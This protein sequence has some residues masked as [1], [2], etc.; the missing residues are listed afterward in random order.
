MRVLAVR[1]GIEVGTAGE[2]DS[3]EDVERLGDAVVRGG[4][5]SG[6]PPARSTARTYAS[7][8]RA[9]GSVQWP[10][11]ASGSAYVVIPIRGRSMT[12]S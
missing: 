1:L 3:V 6:L 5:S 2:H 10:Q 7:G 9:A 11:L 8:I 12:R 4:T